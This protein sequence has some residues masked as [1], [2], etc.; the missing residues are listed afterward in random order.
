MMRRAVVL[1]LLAVAL[2]WA[3][4]EP[5]SRAAD[6]GAETARPTVW[7]WHRKAGD[8]TPHDV[9]FQVLG[10]A[11]AWHLWA[12]VKGIDHRVPGIRVK[13]RGRRDPYA[14][15]VRV[16]IVHRPGWWWGETVTTEHGVTIYLNHAYPADPWVV[17]HEFLHA[18]GMDHH[19]SPGGMLSV[20]APSL[21]PI[22]PSELHALR[23]AYRTAVRQ[24]GT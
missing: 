2:V 6:R 24:P 4:G 13:V 12:A 11:P 10:R 14:I 7:A 17:R 22:S 23:S 5:P 9:N 21:R 3:L 16:R 15:R 8:P 1:V 19:T 18:L 20:P